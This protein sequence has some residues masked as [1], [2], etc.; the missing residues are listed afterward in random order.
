MRN[1]SDVTDYYLFYATNNR[2]GL[3]KIK[4]AMWKVDESGGFLS[5]TPLILTKVFCFPN[6]LRLKSLSIR[7]CAVFEAEKQRSARSRISSFL[8]PPFV[9][10]IISDTSSVPWS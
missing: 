6:N 9:R 1:E 10:P 8:R 5:P 7:Y 2:K 3:E 4:E